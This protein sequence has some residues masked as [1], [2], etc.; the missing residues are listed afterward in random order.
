MMLHILFPVEVS[1]QDGDTGQDGKEEL[2]LY[3]EDGFPLLEE[4]KKQKDLYHHSCEISKVSN[5]AARRLGLDAALC[6]AG[7]MFHEIGRIRTGEDYMAN[8][9]RLA[10]EYH[11]RTG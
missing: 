10:D 11:F 6:A 8:S 7:G 1:A 4:L 2:L 3:L 9:I 5:L